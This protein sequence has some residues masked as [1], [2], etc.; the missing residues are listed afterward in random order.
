MRIFHGK[1]KLLSGPRPASHWLDSEQLDLKSAESANAVMNPV[2]FLA[3]GG[4]QFPAID[5][6]HRVH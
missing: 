5:V 4:Y 3:G 1:T 2:Q 6:C